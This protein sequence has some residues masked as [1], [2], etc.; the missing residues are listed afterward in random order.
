MTDADLLRRAKGGESAAW[1]Q[2]YAR[3][4]PAVWRYTYSLTRDQNVTEDVVSETMLA[5]V[6]GLEKL[7]PD[8][9]HLHGWLRRVAS[10]KLSDLGR[11]AVRQH[12]LREAA[13]TD[14]RRAPGQSDPSDL[15]EVAE[16]RTRVMEV[17]D[18]L[19][20]LQRQALESKYMDSLSVRQ[21]AQRFGQTEKAAESLLYR[22]RQEFRR[23]YQ[24]AEQQQI[25]EG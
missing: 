2:L 24:L 20:E 13:S 16:T 8:T 6:R 19:P 23:L 25:A 11:Y 3:V 9:C 10:N 18:Q 21:I 4:L 12:R 5:L 7:E 1:R 22:A 14:P 17:L 15:L